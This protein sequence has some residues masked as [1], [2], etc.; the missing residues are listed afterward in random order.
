M[1]LQV[2]IRLVRRI[3]P[4]IPRT[5]CLEL[6]SRGFL[7]P[8]AA[9]FL[10]TKS[11]TWNWSRLLVPC[12]GTSSPKCSLDYLC[13]S[14]Y[15][16]VLILPHLTLQPVWCGELSLLRGVISLFLQSTHIMKIPEPA[17]LI[18]IT[19]NR[20]WR[21]RVWQALSSLYRLSHFILSDSLPAGTVII[22]AIF[23]DKTTD[24]IQIPLIYLDGPFGIRLCPLLIFF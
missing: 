15:F 4:G 22:I 14:A 20:Y 19:G 9:F 8:P 3:T 24:Q 17:K 5:G 13:P 2:E 18:I 6:V 12:K 21:L 16:S 10:V 7:C 11:I 1:Y 23:T